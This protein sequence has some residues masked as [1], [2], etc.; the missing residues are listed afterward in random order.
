MASK[1]TKSILSE[2][3]TPAERRTIKKRTK[4]NMRRKIRRLD[5]KYDVLSYYIIIAILVLF[6]S[7]WFTVNI[8]HTFEISGGSL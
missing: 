4:T 3:R 5:N 2:R 6:L 7:V 8:M 1:K